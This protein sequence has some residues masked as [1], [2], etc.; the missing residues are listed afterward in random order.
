MLSAVT[1]QVGQMACKL[2]WGGRGGVGESVCGRV[3]V[4]LLSG[5]SLLLCSGDGVGWGQGGDPSVLT[6]LKL[7]EQGLRPKAEIFSNWLK[8]CLMSGAGTKV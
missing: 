2:A 3:S 6:L 7:R 1:S 8:R 5:Q 4:P